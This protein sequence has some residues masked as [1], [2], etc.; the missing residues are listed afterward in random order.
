MWAIKIAFI[1][2]IVSIDKFSYKLKYELQKPLFPK[3]LITANTIKIVGI[4]K[5]KPQRE[6]INLI[7]F[8]FLCLFNANAKG[9][10][11]KQLNSAE[12]KA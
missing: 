6:M 11:K 3:S 8:K 7:I 5:Q 1:P 2:K 4:T 10:A 12:R 9:I